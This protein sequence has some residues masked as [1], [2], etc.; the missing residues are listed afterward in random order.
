MKQKRLAVFTL[1][2]LVLLLFWNAR[3][4]RPASGQ[5]GSAISVQRVIASGL[6]L[7]VGI[8][9]AGDGTNRLFVI[10]K[11]GRI[12]IIKNG[13]VL[14]IPFLDVSALV[15]GGSEQGLLGLAFHPDYATNGFFYVYYTDRVGVGNT[16]VARYRVSSANPDLA[17]PATRTQI[18]YVVQP[19]TNHN[20]GHLAFG[21][22]GY[23]YIAL[24][25]G[26]SGGDPLNSGQRLDTLLGKLLRID[27][28]SGSPYAIPASNP[29]VGVSGARGE[30][31]AYGLRNPWKFS[32]DR[33][34]GDLYIGDVGQN[35][36]EEIDFQAGGSLSGPNYGWRC[37]EGLHTYSTV[38]PCNDPAYLA[39]LIPPI[40]EYA[41]T[42]GVSVTGGHV[43][44]GALFSGLYGRYYYGDFGTGRI[45]SLARLPGSTPA[46]ST[47]VLELE[48]TG[49]NISAFG[50]DEAGEIYLADYNGSI[51]RLES[52]AGPVPNLS[53]STIVPSVP[54]ADRGD[55]V[56]FTIT[57]RN[58]GAAGNLS[59]SNP[60]PA[61][62]EDIRALSASGGVAG[63][64]GQTVT[65]SGAVPE[66]GEVTVRYDVTVSA[67]LADGS[68]VNR[69]AL[70]GPDIDPLEI[71][72]ALWVPAA[73]LH[74]TV[75]NFFL[76]G[77]QPG[78]LSVPLQ[79]SQ[80]CDICHSAPI[81]DRWRGSVMSQAGRDPLAWSAMAV[82]NAFAPNSGEFCLRCHTNKGWLE[83]RSE[84]ADGSALFGQDIANGVACLTCHRMVDGQPSPD[85]EASTIDAL[86]RAG[87][88]FPPP[89][90]TVGSAMLIL[91]P[92]D[93]R[94]GPFS[95]AVTFPYHTALRTDLL[96][97]SGDPV[98]R[99][100]VCGSCHNLSNP[101]LS[102]D[103]GRGEYWP[104]P[105][106]QPAPNFETD[107]ANGMFPIERTFDEWRLSAYANGGVYAPQFAGQKPGGV[108]E[109]CQD[110]H[111][112]RATGAA[113]DAAFNPLQRDCLTTG[114]LP[115]LDFTGANTWLPDL[116]QDPAWRLSAPGEAGYLAGS[117]AITRSF[118]AKAASLAV[119]LDPPAAGSRRVRVTVTNQT[120]HKLPTGYPEGRRMWIHLQAFDAGGSLVYES[121]AYD[122]QTG[123]LAVDPPPKVYE[124]KLGL[125]SNLAALLNLPAGESFF[126]SLNNAWIKDNRI[127]PRG[128][129]QAAFDKDG[130]RPVGYT[131][132][133]GAY[134]DQAEYTVPESAVRV[135]ATLYYQ[136]AS[137]EYVDFLAQFGGI[138]GQTL[139]AL[140][141]NTPGD[142]VVVT[143]GWAPSYP[144]YLPQVHR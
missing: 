139:G 50:E 62:L 119:Q 88:P 35:L 53:G 74:T 98:T 133:D 144:A 23:L 18:L 58:S 84:P 63:I 47:P 126:F 6:T 113:A 43:Y 55:P 121:G 120:G 60:V 9:H 16:V 132:A 41:H 87:L 46:F 77:T 10:E 17:D 61:G 8:T 31:W 71:A 68:L 72:A 143:R 127:P 4:A 116:L 114:C 45:W 57:L 5:T 125:S 21:P 78:G 124:A 42:L 101:L 135:M 39:G 107:A 64:S 89:A 49:L 106:G 51:R 95:L 2:I 76:P 73:V 83:G 20:A 40:A 122:A 81:Y 12:R 94:R 110:C 93:N 130:L 99:A 67:G 80:D 137:K 24:G 105:D 86:I 136:V 44:R 26:G 85:D 13:A 30:I 48:N 1:A 100:R 134:F 52:A 91:D 70:S 33:L 65:W 115:Q 108:V 92:N 131:Y 37:L 109:T 79:I 7:P 15:S 25:D 140:W 32:F 118:L 138:D 69:V 97:Q 117:Q 56:T 75:E 102:Y 22:D 36:W 82:S 29:F 66:D 90:A 128:Y 96:G 59:F 103:A 34:N 54:S 129:T 111:M 112:P 19:Y 123:L 28:D 27:V 11:V 14:P 38:A 3:Q 142:P 141:Q 104:N